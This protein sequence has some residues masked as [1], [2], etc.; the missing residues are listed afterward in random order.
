MFAGERDLA[1]IAIYDLGAHPGRGISGINLVIGNENEPLVRVMERISAKLAHEDRLHYQAVAQI[2]A[3][4]FL[5]WNVELAR[6]VEETAY[7]DA[8]QQLARLGPR[9]AAKVRRRLDHLYDRILLG[10]LTQPGH[11]PRAHGEVSAHWRR[12]HFRMQPHGPQRSLRKIIFIAP[13]L[14]RLTVAAVS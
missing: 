14:D 9:K 5:Y 6:R 2:C 12:G 10:P 13:V 1:L 4:V 7:T 3:K 8:M 11:A